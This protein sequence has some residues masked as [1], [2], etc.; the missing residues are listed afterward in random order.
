MAWV[1]GVGMSRDVTRHVARLDHVD[2]WCNGVVTP[3]RSVNLS[4]RC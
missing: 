1:R 3:Y 2:M 4:L